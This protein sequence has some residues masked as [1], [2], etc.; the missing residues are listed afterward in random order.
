MP[1]YSG[2]G[3]DGSTG[4]ASG[5]R[6]PKSSA[7]PEACGTV[8]ELCAHLGAVLACPPGNASPLADELLKIQ[9]D[10]FAIGVLISSLPGSSIRIK[11]VRDE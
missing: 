7:R 6:V 9:N 2:N 8:D 3:D 5:E 4:L 10:L 1:L 11:C